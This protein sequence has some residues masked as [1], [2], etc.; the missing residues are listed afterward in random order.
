MIGIYLGGGEGGDC[1]AVLHSV[2][3]SNMGK[4]FIF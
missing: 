2:S 3:V 4:E 1:Y